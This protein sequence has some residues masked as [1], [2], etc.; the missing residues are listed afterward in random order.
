MLD[1]FVFEN[2]LGQRF[3]G[4]PN[5]VYLNYSSLRDYAWG[6]DTLNSRI[7]RFYKK[8]TS[9]SLPL[10]ICANSGEEAY[11]AMNRLHELAERDIEARKPGRVY[12]NGYYTTGYITQSKKSK[13]LIEE[14]FCKNQLTFVS[15]DPNWYRE[16]LYSFQP[17]SG[18]AVVTGADYP[19]DYSYDYA[20]SFN[21]KDI[22]LAT[23]SDSA[24]RLR[25]YGE[26]GNPSVSIA[27]NTY[28]VSGDIAAGESLLIDS[29]NKTIVLTQV[30]G[31]QVN[32]FDKRSRDGYIF[33]PLPPGNLQVAWNNA[34]GFDLT[35]IE[36]RSEPKW[37]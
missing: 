30:T 8:V 18:T 19:Y 31:N 26:A 9:R 34:F 7:S 1:S 2:H 3:E 22:P 21:G 33:E 37:I 27:G 12:I 25:I 23:T 29:L 4:L 15:D 11:A 24:F 14:R 32:W 17:E 5:G 10:V 36:K 16:T 28:G 6:Y 35:V 13:Y 20:M